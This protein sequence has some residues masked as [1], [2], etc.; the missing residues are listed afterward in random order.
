M[1]SADVN[2]SAFYRYLLLLLCFTGLGL[3]QLS[4]QDKGR[5][6]P[7][8]QTNIKVTNLVG[9][10]FVIK[11]QVV[12]GGNGMPIPFAGVYFRGTNVG[13]TTDIDG[14]YSLKTRRVG[15]SLTVK[16]VGYLE[17]SVFIR[18]SE[19]QSI[20]FKLEPNIAQLGEVVIRAGENPAFRILR[21]VWRKRDLND[22]R[23]LSAF[24]YE[25]YTKLEVDM[26]EVSERVRDK[27]LM[28]PFVTL[29]DSLK[30]MHEGEKRYVLPL[31]FSESISDFYYNANPYRRKEHIR[32]SRLD[33]VGV[34][35]GEFVAQMMGSSF[36]DFNF[37]QD[38]VPIFDKLFVAAGR[39][40]AFVL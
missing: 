16:V 37:Y 30:M 24:E 4:A 2:L 9:P 23:Q 1:Y 19:N 36:R 3:V 25:S 8:P 40:G 7:L 34:E 26:D 10:E 21:G 12:D 35:D 22:R 14:K 33:G 39:R 18:K 11:G 28:K 31:F 5:S 27:K 13:T 20:E 17:K 29:F 32:A 6:L 38:W 15:D